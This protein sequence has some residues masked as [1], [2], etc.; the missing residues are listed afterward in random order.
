MSLPMSCYQDLLARVRS[1]N[2][3]T[4]QLHAE[5]SGYKDPNFGVNQNKNQ[6]NQSQSQG[7]LSVSSRSS[8]MESSTNDLS[9]SSGASSNLYQ[10][11]VPA[12]HEFAMWNSV[13]PGVNRLSN[14]TSFKSDEGGVAL[15][16]RSYSEAGG[17]GGGLGVKVDMV[18]GLIS[19]LDNHNREEMS[20]T[21]LAMS[22]SPDSCDAMRQ[23]GCISLLVQL[24]HCSE[25]DCTV[26]VKQRASQALHNLIHCHQDDKGGRREVRVLRLLEKIRLYADTMSETTQHSDQEEISQVIAALMKLSFDEDH[27]HAMCQLGALYTLAKLITVDTHCHGLNNKYCIILRRY[28]GMTLTNLTFGHGNNKSTLC[29]LTD[30]MKALV[31]QLSTPSDHLRQ[32]TASV[33]RNLSWR[34]DVKSKSILREVGAVP[35][36]MQSAM[37]TSKESTLKSILSALW[38]FSAHCNNNKVDICQVQGALPFLI[39]KMKSSTQTSMTIVEN[40]GGVMRNISSHISVKENYRAILREHQCLPLLLEQLRSPSLTVVSNA[41]GTL[42]NLSARCPQ[43]QAT[44]CALGAGPMLSSLIHSRHKMIAMGASAALKNLLNAAPAGGGPGAGPEC[45]LFEKDSRGGT[46]SLL[47]RK[48]RALEKELDAN[49]AETC[50][51]ID[52]ADLASPLT[53]QASTPLS[54][55]SV[56]HHMLTSTPNGSSVGDHDTLG[57]NNHV[58]DPLRTPR[59]P[60]SRTPSPSFHNKTTTPTSTSTHSHYETP[61]SQFNNNDNDDT[62]PSHFSE[63]SSQSHYNNNQTPQS[64]YNSPHDSAKTSYSNANVDR[65]SN[66]HYTPNESAKNSHYSPCSEGS[67]ISNYNPNENGQTSNYKPNENAQNS[68]YNP[69]ER[70]TNSHYD[71]ANSSSRYNLNEGSQNSNGNE[72]DLCYSENE[73]NGNSAT[74]ESERDRHESR[75]N[76]MERER[77]D[78]DRD[79][80]GEHQPPSSS[81]GD[82]THHHEPREQA[83][84]SKMEEPYYQN[85]EDLE[86]SNEPPNLDQPT[87]Y[88]LRYSEAKVPVGGDKQRSAA[89]SETAG[90]ERNHPPSSSEQQSRR[91]LTKFDEAEVEGEGGDTVT[92]FCTEDTPYNFSNATSLSDLRITDTPGDLSACKTPEDSKPGTPG[93]GSPSPLGPRGGPVGPQGVMG[94]D[95]TPLMFSRCSSLDSVSSCGGENMG[96]QANP[97]GGEG[98]G[99]GVAPEDRYSVVSEF[100][101]MTSGMISPSDLPDSPIHTAPVSPS[102]RGSAPSKGFAFPSAP[103]MG[104]DRAKFYPPGGG[105]AGPAHRSVFEDTVATYKHDDDEEEEGKGGINGDSARPRP[106]GPALPPPPS[107]AK[108]ELRYYA[109]EESPQN[110]TAWSSLSD[111]SINTNTSVSATQPPPAK[112]EVKMLLSEDTECKEEMLSDEHILQACIQAGMESAKSLRLQDK[113][114]KPSSQT[115]TSLGHNMDDDEDDG[116]DDDNV[117]AQCIQLGMTQH[118]AAASTGGHAGAAKVTQ[119]AD[120]TAAAG[121]HSSPSTANKQSLPADIT[122]SGGHPTPAQQRLGRPG[123]ES[124]VTLTPLTTTD[125]GPSNQGSSSSNPVSATTGLSIPTPIASGAVGLKIDLSDEEILQQ[126]ILEGMSSYVTHDETLLTQCIRAGMEKFKLEIS[127]KKKQSTSDMNNT[128]DR[129]STTTTPTVPPSDN[130]QHNRD[131]SSKAPLDL[132]QNSITCSSQ[133]E[134]DL[135]QWANDVQDKDTALLLEQC[136]EAGIPHKSKNVVA[137]SVTTFSPPTAQASTKPRTD[138]DENH[139]TTTTVTNDTT[140]ATRSAHGGEGKYSTQT[141]DLTTTTSS[142]V[143]KALPNKTVELI[144]Q[145]SLGGSSTMGTSSTIDKAMTM[146]SSWRLGDDLNDDLC[147]GL[148]PTGPLINEEELLS[149]RIEAQDLP[150]DMKVSITNTWSEDSSS[151]YP[152]VSLSPPSCLKPKQATFVYEDIAGSNGKPPSKDLKQEA[153]RLPSLNADSDSSVTNSPARKS[154][155]KVNPFPETAKHLTGEVN[156]MSQQIQAGN[157]KLGVGDDLMEELIKNSANSMGSLGPA[158][159]ILLTSDQMKFSILE[160]ESGKL[161]II[162]SLEFEDLNSVKPPSMMESL[163]C[164]DRSMYN[165]TLV[166]SM[167]SM[168]SSI[169]LENVK[170]PSYFDD[171]SFLMEDNNGLDASICNIDSIVSEIADDDDSTLIEDFAD[172]P[173]DSGSTLEHQ[174]AYQE[175]PGL[176]RRVTP[177]QKRTLSQERYNTYTIQSEELAATHLNGVGSSQ[178]NPSR[179]TPKQR[180]QQDRDRYST[181]TILD[182]ND[183]TVVNHDTFTVLTDDTLTLMSGNNSEIEDL[184]LDDEPSPPPP[185]PVRT[186]AITSNSS[187]GKLGL[188]KLV[189]PKPRT[190]IPLSK[191]AEPKVSVVKVKSVLPPQRQGTFTKDEPSTPNIS[192]IPVLASQSA[193]STPKKTTGS[194]AGSHPGITLRNN[195]QPNIKR[196]SGVRSSL[197]NS[198]LKGELRDS[199]LNTSTPNNLNRRSYVDL[200]TSRT[201]YTRLSSRRKSASNS[202]SSLNSS[203]S[204]GSGFVKNSSGSVKQGVGSER[205]KASVTSVG[206]KQGGASIVK[207]VSSGKKLSGGGTSPPVTAGT[208]GPASKIANLLKKI[209]DT[210]KATGAAALGKKDTRVWITK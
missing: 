14:S 65:S 175:S 68:H 201:D 187:P 70:S 168:H 82:E 35:A 197:S 144:K 149:R 195:S 139:A 108:D 8:T 206:A 28:A 102:P 3:E 44:L 113:T 74:R 48:R 29:C 73:R 127:K 60:R 173:L 69:N 136:I 38:N 128:T 103:P 132:S 45:N 104:P 131:S 1:I 145:S 199:K 183:D 180:R 55:G 86:D 94:C 64:Q 22:H 167:T 160:L 142:S 200:S 169:N 111:L 165:K 32:V 110:L 21:L 42:W 2:E 81:R 49:L 52:N 36:L 205:A 84:F 181:R 80:T 105:K 158:E 51:N 57:D 11:P 171:V 12:K 7:H 148:E 138:G 133:A 121:A 85:L 27:R 190:N 90:S 20:R 37:E 59:S 124:A 176:K 78:E 9:S 188:S 18:Y 154:V 178:Q 19:M 109:V 179:L 163:T 26:E 191:L 16:S 130:T 67:R 156:K 146:S 118:N 125:Q 184:E 166:G 98:G 186:N 106:G 88:S 97:G 83:S 150:D 129:D 119:S 123:R 189:Q 92:R 47:I 10:N 151:S 208:G 137:P 63:T 100:S 194:P 17:G 140:T 39:E 114:A 153:G 141:S 79:R 120:K 122:K 66:S 135:D 34:A 24:I 162:S 161:G 75:Y 143:P 61:G 210:K 30:F 164:L 5:I 159:S 77:R 185:P 134:F 177:K 40:A 207:T 203:S 174:A 101:R 115:S 155:A 46:P 25:E 53:P 76:S 41:C 117:L 50:D 4:K 126:C 58:E 89:S 152:T 71:S 147:E 56:F 72:S 6:T 33:L 172:I 204:S 182:D 196:N 23:S 157:E 54:G 31:L 202:N 13:G 99:D 93:R 209:E 87:D 107:S 112:Q 198:N 62:P 192:S 193:Q 96:P 170:P 95:E 116:A 15:T 43:D 91:D